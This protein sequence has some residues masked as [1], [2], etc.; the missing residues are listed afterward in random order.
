MTANRTEATI[1]AVIAICGSAGDGSI[2]A[3]QILNMAATAMGYHV[4][5]FDSYPAEIRGFGKSVAHS[6]I[7]RDKALTPGTQV[8]CLVALDDPHSITELGTVVEDGVVIYDSRPAQYHEEDMAVAGW[9]QPGMVGYGVP[10]RELSTR[11]TKSARSRNIVALGVLARLLG[12]APEAFR[13][14]IR[15]RWAGKSAGMRDAN[16]EAFDLGYEYAERELDKADAIDFR[17]QTQEPASEVRII[18][19][20]DA[21]AKACVDAGLRLYAGYPI[22]PATKIMEALAK[23]LPRRGGLVLQT[24]DEISAICHVIGAG[25]AGR[26]ACTA[27]SGP[28]LCLMVEALNLAVMAEVP[29]VVIDS[30]RGGPS[31]GLPTKTEQSDLNLAI[32]GASGDSP[33]VVL[34]PAD[35]GECYH[36]TRTAFEVAEAFQTPV[37]VLLD[38]FL[39]NRM[40]DIR[41]DDGAGIWGSY[42]DVLAAPR[43][44]GY[45]RFA[46]SETGVSPRAYPGMEGLQHPIT[47]LEHTPNGLAA[48]T[49]ENHVRMMAKRQRKMD[50][51]A[52]AWPTPEVIGGGGTLAVGVLSWGSTVGASKNALR[53]LS[54]EGVELGGF[55]PRLMW[56]LQA[57][58]M[59][60]F[61]ERCDRL[62]VAETNHSGQLANLVEQVTRREVVRIAE[63]AARPLPT[64]AVVEAI[65]SIL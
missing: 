41:W 38:F 35:V 30:Q 16:I 4:M 42:S 39:S 64:R 6:R 61:A 50:T 2:V 29:C 26:R 37:I 31:T 19:G 62:V 56:P 57:D 36:V 13:D 59:R 18:S 40:E 9:I 14:S 7:S 25:F 21:A 3:G 43:D 55:F 11:A 63:A 53:A 10:L 45:Q 54:R 49:G 33:R 47:G 44:E 28:G 17:G 5:G 65:R 51:L 58:A 48:Y 46:F 1:D 15:R 27:T 60:A 52:S 22:T 23:E 12:L 8:D 32:Y 20:N 24:E 34:A